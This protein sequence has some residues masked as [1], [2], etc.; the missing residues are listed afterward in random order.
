[1][2]RPD[3]EAQT[4]TVTDRMVRDLVQTMLGSARAIARLPIFI[5]SAA[6]GDYGPIARAVAAEGPPPPRP[7]PRGLFLSI[8]C[9]ESIPLI[10]PDSVAAATA[11]TFF[12]AAPVRSQMDACARWPRSELPAGFWEPA[13]AG[14]PVLVISGDLDPITPPSY[15]EHVASQLPNARHLIVANRSHGDVDPCITGLFE[16]FI[17]AGSASG[18]DTTCTAAP[19]HLGFVLSAEELAPAH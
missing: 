16:R 2:A 10:H 5:H 13:R 19:A 12:G 6:G 7:A 14:V 11:G 4:V 8:L 17:L 3:G 1:L 18:L 9:G 15:G